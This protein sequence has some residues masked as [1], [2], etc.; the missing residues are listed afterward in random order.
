MSD[1]QVLTSEEI[2]ATF[3]FPDIVFRDGP[4]GRRPGLAQ[5]PDIWEMVGIMRAHNWDLAA[6]ADYLEC[7]LWLF[8]IALAYYRLRTQEIDEWIETNK[9]AYRELREELGGS[10]LL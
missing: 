8:E 3:F 2:A 7:E 4:A 5:G 9:R 1:S 6:C 10:T